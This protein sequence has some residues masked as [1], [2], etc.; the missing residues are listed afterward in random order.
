MKIWKYISCLIIITLSSICAFG[1]Q[2]FHT[3]NTNIDY[4]MENGSL[5]ITSR[6][7]T[8]GIE[9]AIGEKT[10]N[11]ANFDSKLKNYINNK[12][13]LKIDGK[14]IN[15]SYIGFQAN[16]QTTRVYLKVE[17][18]NDINSLDIKFALLMDVYDDQQNFLNLDIKN[19]R[20]KLVIRKENEIVKVNF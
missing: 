11:K 2:N 13:I 16:E 3:S 15:L 10:V 6:L 19:N 5:N 18:I 8:N 7:Y 14:P 1:Q 17:K 12:V 9:K 20:K 4:E